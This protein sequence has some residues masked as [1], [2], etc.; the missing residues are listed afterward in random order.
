MSAAHGV[1]QGSVQ[2]SGARPA[3]GEHVPVPPH[4]PVDDAARLRACW[5][6]G[7]TAVGLWSVLTD[8]MVAELVGA[9]DA[10]VV[11]VDAQHG[12]ADAAWL[13]VALQGWRSVGRV[14]VARARWNDPGEIMRVL[15]AGASGVIV[16]MVSTAQDAVEAARACRY[17]PRGIRSWGPLWA[18]RG[19]PDPTAQD[20]AVLCVVMIETA[21]AVANLEEI[22]AV[23]GVDAVYIGPNDLALSCG[24]GRASYRTSVA[25]DELLR[26]VVATCRERGVPVGLHCSDVEMARTWRDRGV[27]WVTSG[28]DADLLAAATRATVTAMRAEV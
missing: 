6:R 16:P 3:A 18:A 9:S 5:R 23:P 1:A 14:P 12:H 11:V 2:G 17:P 8:P 7:A 15:D 19:V 21:E 4:V 22:L 13:P 20:E 25:V 28:T 10:D 24:Y 26:R 27:S